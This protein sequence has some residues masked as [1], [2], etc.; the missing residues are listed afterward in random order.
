MNEILQRTLR[1]QS[2]HRLDRNVH[3][4]KAILLK[5]DLA[6]P[7][8]VD[9]RV[10]RRLG[11]EDFPACRIDA[12]L[13]LERVVPQMLH[14]FPVAHNSV[15]HRLRDLQEVARLCSLIADH[16]I[17]DDACGTHA[18]FSAQNRPSDDRRE[19]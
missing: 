10:H 5:H 11:E 4:P 14:V 8:S 2:Q 19:Y 13:L 18:L 3:A 9:L 1:I 6:H 7:L 16:D 17:F 15:L 12:Q